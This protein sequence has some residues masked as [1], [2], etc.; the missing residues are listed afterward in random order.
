MN[1]IRPD[2]V[3]A[4]QPGRRTATDYIILHH[5]ASEGSAE[6]IHAFH[7][8]VKG[9]AGIAY[10]YYIR[11]DGS[12]YQGREENWNGGH[13]EGYNSRSI[14]V[15]FE[16]NFETER[17]TDAQILAGRELL[18]ALKGRYPDALTVRHGELNRTACPGKNFPFAALTENLPAVG[19]N[20]GEQ[21]SDWARESVERWIELGIL[22]GDGSGSYGLQETVTLERMVTLV[23]R[24]IALLD[25]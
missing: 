22:R 10:H 19:E 12:V 25:R 4:Y 16:G 6:D 15:C 23:E 9:W 18:A 3:W 20:A 14:G 8:D 24:R 2:Y 1:I 13:T 5:A 7:R 17:M 11:R 21:P